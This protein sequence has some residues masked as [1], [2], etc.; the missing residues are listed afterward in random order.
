VEVPSTWVKRVADDGISH[1]WYDTMAGEAQWHG[2]SFNV[3]TALTNITM[4]DTK[5]MKRPS[6]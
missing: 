5:P 3:P 2:P 6:E 1:Y 4:P